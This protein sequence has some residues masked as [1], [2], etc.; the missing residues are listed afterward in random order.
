MLT[1]V[2]NE[3]LIKMLARSVQ[4]NRV[5]SHQTQ[6]PQ[7]KPESQQSISVESVSVSPQIT[8]NSE[9]MR[10][11]K[12]Q[13]PKVK[14]S[15]ELFHVD[16]MY[17]LDSGGQPQFLDILPLLFRNENSNERRRWEDETS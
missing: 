15:T 8:S 9:A 11:I 1:E 5:T 17:L 13:L 4:S 12:E 16:W 7:H 14:P 6:E 10:S 3:E 2:D